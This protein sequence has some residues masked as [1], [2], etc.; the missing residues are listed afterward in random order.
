M[1]KKYIKNHQYLLLFLIVLFIIGIIIGIVLYNVMPSV[2]QTSLTINLD[3]L[4]DQV[5]NNHL[6]NIV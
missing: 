4:K 1:L 6:S 5:L 2:N 3:N